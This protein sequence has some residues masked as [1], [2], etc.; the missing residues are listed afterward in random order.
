MAITRGYQNL[1]GE[2]INAGRD[3]LLDPRKA[4]GVVAAP[5]DN[6]G[7]GLEAL[8]NRAWQRHH[9]KSELDKPA[10]EQALEQER[11]CPVIYIYI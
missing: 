2:I 9:T 8:R 1:N 5:G 6:V 3:G 10:C 11:A 4:K 7:A